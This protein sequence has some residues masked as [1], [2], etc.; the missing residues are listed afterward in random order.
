[1]TTGEKIRYYRL[2]RGFSVQSLSD[3]IGVA[4]TTVIRWE[5]GQTKKIDADILPKLSKAL[6]VPESFLI[7]D[8]DIPMTEG[9]AALLEP[10]SPEDMV[11]DLYDRFKKL[12]E[13]QRTLFFARLYKEISDQS[14]LKQK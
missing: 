5:N 10:I 3:E 1:M 7:R 4:K 12:D 6:F 14:E 8:D 2:Q 9:E 13:H 11:Q